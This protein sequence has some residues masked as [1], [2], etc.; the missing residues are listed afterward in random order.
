[1][2]A[3]QFNASPM[4]RKHDFDVMSAIALLYAHVVVGNGNG[5]AVMSPFQAPAECP[6]EQEHLQTS[7]RQY[8][9]EAAKGHEAR[10]AKGGETQRAEEEERPARAQGA[11][12]N[13]LDSLLQAT[14]HAGK[15]PPF[16]RAAMVQHRRARALQAQGFF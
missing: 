11:V 14:G 5:L 9:P 1:M 10:D 4:P 16:P 7:E 6:A 13:D 12:R 15:S 3:A 8:R 2:R